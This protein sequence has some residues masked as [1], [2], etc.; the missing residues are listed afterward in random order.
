MQQRHISTVIWS[1]PDID[2]ARCALCSLSQQRENVS[3]SNVH[4]IKAILYVAE[5][6]YTWRVN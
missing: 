6:G 3:L 4:V 1:L 2:A 5:Q